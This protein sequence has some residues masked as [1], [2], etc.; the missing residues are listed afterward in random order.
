MRLSPELRE[1]LIRTVTAAGVALALAVVAL[2][3]PTPALAAPSIDSVRATPAHD[4]A[5]APSGIEPPLG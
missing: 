5:L 3:S 4:T 2:A 1:R